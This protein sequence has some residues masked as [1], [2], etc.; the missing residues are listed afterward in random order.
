[1]HKET[2]QDKTAMSAHTICSFCGSNHWRTIINDLY[3]SS[4]LFPPTVRLGHFP[5]TVVWALENNLSGRV[6]TAKDGLQWHTSLFHH[7]GKDNKTFSIPQLQIG[8]HVTMRWPQMAY[9]Q[10]VF[11]STIVFLMAYLRTGFHAAI[12]QP[13]KAQI[14]SFRSQ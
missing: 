8:F 13:P 10:I 11:H 6:T 3:R 9:R 12:R 1:M 14:Q 2:V 7:H 5:A 4:R